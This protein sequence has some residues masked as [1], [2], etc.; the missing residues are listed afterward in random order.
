MKRFIPFPTAFVI[1]FLI[2][3]VPSIPSADSNDPINIWQDNSCITELKFQSGSE[4]TKKLI[5]ERIQERGRSSWQ[6]WHQHVST[7]FVGKVVWAQPREEADRIACGIAI[8]SR[9]VR[10]SVTEVLLGDIWVGSEI[11]VR[12]DWCEFYKDKYLPGAMFIIGLNTRFYKNIPE[13]ATPNGKLGWELPFSPANR[14]IA[15]NFIQCIHEIG[16]VKAMEEE[17]ENE[18]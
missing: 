15:Q 8:G 10:H 13:M 1:F 16:I 14:E 3:S 17:K 18:E 5:K 6:G 4:V 12:H 9:Y 2:V 7:V 11:K